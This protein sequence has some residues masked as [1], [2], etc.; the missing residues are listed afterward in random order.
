[1]FLRGEVCKE[2]SQVLKGE[3]ANNNLS[4]RRVRTRTHGV[5]GGRRL[6]T[7]SYPI[8]EGY[9]MFN[10]HYKDN[11]ILNCNLAHRAKGIPCIR[12]FFRFV[13]VLC[14]SDTKI[15]ALYR[16]ICIQILFQS[17][18][19]PKLFFHSWDIQPFQCVAYSLLLA[20][21]T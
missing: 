7:V 5:V 6:D 4:K 17:H 11:H 8:L 13:L 20:F 19:A 21:V 12:S 14:K 2:C 3:V 1:M 10:H 16:Q 15:A 9:S 18:F